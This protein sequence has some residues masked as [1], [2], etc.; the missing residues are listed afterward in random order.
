MRGLDSYDFPLPRELIAQAPKERREESRLMILE[1]DGTRDDFFYN[2]PE[3]VEAGDTIVIND[4]RVLQAKLGGTRKTGGR[5]ELLIFERTSPVEAKALVKGRARIGERLEFGQFSCVVKSREG[6]IS[7]VEFGE[8]LDNVLSE[9][10]EM[11]LPPYIKSKLDDFDR[12]QTV[13]ASKEGSIAAPTAG[14][15]FSEDVLGKL[16]DKGANI[17][18][19]T[20]HI[21]I[22]TFLPQD[23]SL[24]IPEHFRIEDSAANGINRTAENGGR[25]IV[26]G[27]STFKCLESSCVDGLIMPKEGSSSLFISPPYEFKFR[28]HAMLTNF[29]LPKSPV[30]LLTCAY[31]G[32]SRLLSAYEKAIEQSYRFYSFGDSMLI[33]DGRSG[34]PKAD[35]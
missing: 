16:K 19:V 23:G 12:Y 28:P 26:V 4:S 35:I 33:F 27:T 34:N 24:S 7:E 15:H 32:R 9:E 20:L 18:K 8:D 14:L 13:Y 3:Y 30:L 31:A 25:V 10:G 1:S 2:L 11:P 6:G 21:N 5:V 29:H 17:A 22:G